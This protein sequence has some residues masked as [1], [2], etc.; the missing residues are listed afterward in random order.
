M[1]LMWNC[2][3]GSDKSIGAERCD[4][5]W[6][7]FLCYVEDAKHVRH[8]KMLERCRVHG[9]GQ[10]MTKRMSDNADELLDLR[11]HTLQ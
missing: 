6:K 4:E 7:E 11:F 9:R 8:L 10:C 3:T 5:R 1:L 2:D